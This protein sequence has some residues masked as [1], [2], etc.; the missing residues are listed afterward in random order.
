MGFY[1]IAQFTSYETVKVTDKY[2]TDENLFWQSHAVS[3]A[4]YVNGMEG[5]IWKKIMP[6]VLDEYIMVI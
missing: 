6:W 3:T 5:G 2:Q 1:C 4:W